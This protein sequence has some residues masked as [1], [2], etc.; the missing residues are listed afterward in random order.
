VQNFYQ[1]LNSAYRMLMISGDGRGI[2]R[3][4]CVFFVFFYVLFPF[5]SDSVFCR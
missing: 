2:D 4:Y 1:S 5:E 3:L